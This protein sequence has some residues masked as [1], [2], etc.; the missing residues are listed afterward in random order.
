MSETK[1]YSAG[2]Y[3]I[4]AT[5][6]P[7]VN[8]NSFTGIVE[9]VINE[10]VGTIFQKQFRY[11]PDNET[12]SEFVTLDVASLG[13]VAFEPNGKLYFQFRFT[14]LSGG[15]V[16]VNGVTLSYSTFPADTFEGFV[17]ANLQDQTRVYAYP[18]TYK[19]GA[20]WDPYKMNRAVRL[21]KDLNLMVNTM[22]GH[23]VHYYRALP[24]GRSKDVFL[25]EYS[26][27]EHDNR[28]CMKIVVPNN[29]F[30][31]NKYNMGPFGVEFEFPF[32]VQ[33]D[34]D[35]FQAIFG[36]G[37]GPQKRDVLFFPRTN[38]IYEVSSSYLFRDFMNEPLYFKLMLQK[39]NPKSNAEMSEDLATL[40]DLTVSVEKLFGVAQKEE[41]TDVAN[42]VQFEQNTYISDPV[43]SYLDDSI[44]IS[45]TQLINNYLNVAEYQYKL[46]STVSENFISVSLTAGNLSLLSDNTYY[47]RLNRYSSPGVTASYPNEDYFYSMRK[48]KYE[49]TDVE[50]NA[51]FELS[52]GGSSLENTYSA[53]QLF[54]PSSSFSLY[55]EEF[56]S[57][58]TSESPLFTCAI[59]ATA[60]SY[61]RP[62]VKYNALCEFESTEDRAVSVWF[63]TK[64]NE[65]FFSNVSSFSVDES[66]GTV[67]FTYAVP[68][69]FIVGE[70]ISVRR[71]SGSNFNL[72]GEII[73]VNSNTSVTVRVSQPMFLHL[74]TVFSSWKS[75]TDLKLQLTYP[76][77]FIDSRKAGKG[78]RVDL[79]ENRYFR[80]FCNDRTYFFTLPN[81]TADITEDKWYSVV[82]S[83]SNLFTQLT[84]N[85]WEMQ[86][87]EITKLPATSDLR[88]I[89]GKTETSFP[90]VDRSS[91][92]NYFLS[93]SDIDI[94]NVRVWSQKIETEKQPFVLNQNIVKDASK[95]L[96]IDNA[97]PR[98][99]M[100]YISYTH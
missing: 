83:F 40:E 15:P 94:T 52:A 34:K 58:A 42:P 60:M 26:L 61:Q 72:V 5:K 53:W 17:P 36:D 3:V 57:S 71:I 6:E 18:V 70:H 4:L 44:E 21:Y 23:E 90:K 59:N 88:L 84:F 32:E 89:Y 74:D 33:I 77:I 29:L 28:Q 68:H 48:A 45:D 10:G 99:R 56:S 95:A 55:E 12:F 11:S 7:Y 31:D 8:A 63:R 98:S 82:V 76:R 54:G 25:L 27:Y 2:D 41:M 51:I 30:P 75:F 38:R 35:Y 93:S 47:L 69:G 24:S 78:I 39:W 22:F 79:L 13:T 1:L 66:L 19:T 49:G 20:K 9:D 50:G 14:L 87:N 46:Q 73:S 43:R 96:V 16:T 86:W 67:D 100:P 85:L 92:I 62:V 81:T 64:K 97:I 80:V 65:H 91:G 37:T